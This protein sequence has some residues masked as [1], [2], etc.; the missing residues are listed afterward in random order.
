MCAV[1]YAG[2]RSLVDLYKALD[3]GWDYK[4]SDH[5]ADEPPVKRQRTSTKFVGRD[6]FS[7]DIADFWLRRIENTNA[8]GRGCQCIYRI[9]PVTNT[10]AN[11]TFRQCSRCDA[12]ENE[13]NEQYEWYYERNQTVE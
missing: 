10:I 9:D 12:Q 3:C 1:T 8:S 4:R 13:L 7:V 2:L 5:M 11:R 6:E